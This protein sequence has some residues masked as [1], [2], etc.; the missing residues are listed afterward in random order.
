[1]C[2][3]GRTTSRPA[4]ATIPSVTEVSRT[5]L[6]CGELRQGT[7]QTE[8]KAFAQQAALV[9]HSRSGFPPVVFHK[10]DLQDQ[11]DSSLASKIRDEISDSRRQVVA[12]VINAVDDHL[13]K[14]QQLHINWTCDTIKT[15][16]PLLHEAQQAERLVVLAS[17]H[18]HVLDHGTTMPCEGK[19][20]WRAADGPPKDY[21]LLMEGSRV[22]LAEGQNLIA[23][24]TESVRYSRGTRNG[25]HG[26]ATPQEM[27]I[28]VTVLSAG[29]EPPEGWSETPLETPIW[30][31]DAATDVA[32]APV[33][34]LKPVEVKEKGV[35]FNIHEPPE[36]EPVEVADP[37]TGEAQTVPDWIAALQ[38]SPLLVEQKQLAGRK[39][40]TDEVLINI[41][42]AVDRHGGKL[43]VNALARA[44][45]MPP[46]RLPGLMVIIQRILN[47]DGYAVM[48]IDDSSETVELDRA[49]LCRQF[50]LVEE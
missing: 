41:L 31:D 25:Y 32:P 8:D 9:S 20:R 2:V 19:E 30:W 6:F 27:V 35:L 1:M 38:A 18:G 7:A 45:R 24:W 4:L 49:L 42:V 22:M 14:A 37:K 48:Q 23:P 29:Q 50:D 34:K 15:L 5:S 28:P 39:V 10:V 43:T 11:Q 47:I 13:L 36:P 26:G 44:I 12:A 21:E 3:T 33:V 40:P 46:L 17:D 16:S